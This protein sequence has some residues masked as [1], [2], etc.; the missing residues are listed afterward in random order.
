MVFSCAWLTTMKT[1]ENA[2]RAWQLTC[3]EWRINITMITEELEVDKKNV[4]KF[5][6]DVVEPR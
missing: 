4:R 1:D 3:T 6:W 5:F 2:E